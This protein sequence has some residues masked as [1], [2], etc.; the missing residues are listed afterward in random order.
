MGKADLHIHSS[1]SFDSTSSIEV[2]MEQAAYRNGLDVIAIT[3]HDEIEGS[4]R[5]QDLA[6]L[7]GIE[8]IP[9][10]EISTSEGHL[11]A[12]FIRKFV[13][14]GLTLQETLHRVGEQDGLCIPAHPMARAIHSL[15][16]A[17][18]RKAVSHTDLRRI[19]VGLETINAGLLF[20]RLS[21]RVRWLS[22]ELHL[23]SVGNS[24]SHVAWTIGSGISDFPGR[25]A[26]DLRRALLERR[27]TAWFKVDHRPVRFIVSNSYHMLLR[28]MGLVMWAP[29]PGA[30]RQ[31]YPLATAHSNS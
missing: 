13:P 27:T 29:E 21:P 30:P 9:G 8:V 14:P 17:T 20:Q 7:Y 12:L 23:A 15:T 6:P 10:I 4:L 26:Q 16:A 18:I 19:L 3:D 11:L 1:Y 31:L 2:V 28:K 25:T 22:E 5:A 24:D